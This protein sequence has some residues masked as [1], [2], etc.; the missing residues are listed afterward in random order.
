[1]YSVHTLVRQF[2]GREAE[3]IG[4]DHQSLLVRAA[5]HYERKAK[6]SRN[7]WD[8]LRARDYYY[9][10]KE[11]EMAADIVICCLGVSSS[12]GIHRASYGPA[13]AICGYDVWCYESNSQGKSRH[14]VSG[15]G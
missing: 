12:L 11:W 3:K 6:V 15:R 5:Q 10:A 13:A 4:V 14:F 8:H 2:A 7:L 1:M 9:Q